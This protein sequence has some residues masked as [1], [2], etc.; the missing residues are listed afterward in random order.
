[1]KAKVENILEYAKE[2]YLQ[3][4]Y[5]KNEY[6]EIAT[7]IV[8]AQENIRNFAYTAQDTYMGSKTALDE[9]DDIFE[10]VI[11]NMEYLNILSKSIN[12]EKIFYLTT[13][14]DEEIFRLCCDFRNSCSE[15][16]IKN[17]PPEK[18]FFE[19]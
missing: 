11:A 4:N 6:M 10:S 5:T 2:G 17:P 13:E 15:Y 14:S 18:Q 16:A 12:N 9:S 3:N 7:R 1:M 8:N 19:N